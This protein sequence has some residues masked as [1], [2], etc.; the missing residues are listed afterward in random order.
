MK[1]LSKQEFAYV[2]D[3]L[4]PYVDQVGGEL[5]AKALIGGTTS[6]VINLRTGIK[7]RQALNLLNSNIVI[8][9]G[10]CGWN[11][12][13]DTTTTFTQHTITTCAKKYN[14]SLCYQDLYDT[15]QSMLM[16]PGQIQDSV[17]FEEQIMSLKVAQLQ[18]Y[19]EREIWTGTT[20]STCFEGFKSLISTGSTFAS[21]IANS[22]GST[23]TVTGSTTTPGNPIYECNK[24]LNVLS[25]DALSRNDLVIFMSYP[26][27]LKLVQ[28]LT[29]AN[30]FQNYIGSTDVTSMMVATLPNT[31]V[32]IY[33]TIG[34]DGSNQ[35]TIGPAEYMVQGVDLTSDDERLVSWYSQDFDQIRFR[36]NFN[37]GVTI[38]TF[39]TTKYFATNN[40]A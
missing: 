35:V 18:Q 6:K 14:E 13:A 22:S 33:P 11:P 7:G 8:Q 20:G 32:K 12:D 38:A 27:F 21:A 37:F 3:S 29:A 28:A 9:D 30:Y 19:V 15:Y 25:A 40:L 10:V 39:G 17:P 16:K 4:K 31:N 34:L 5:L 36:A 26:N 24:L 23:F 2:V 1:I